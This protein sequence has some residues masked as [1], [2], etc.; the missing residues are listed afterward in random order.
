MSNSSS[1][2]AHYQ[3]RIHRWQEWCQSM[4][5]STGG[6][7]TPKYALRW[8]YTQVLFYPN[9][10]TDISKQQRQSTPE[11]AETS[12]SGARAAISD[13]LPTYSIEDVETSLDMVEES[14]LQALDVVEDL[15]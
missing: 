8:I 3:V 5:F 15:T 2:Q 10:G 11:E 6:M 14:Q 1:T 7:V 13:L 4:K 12:A 9:N